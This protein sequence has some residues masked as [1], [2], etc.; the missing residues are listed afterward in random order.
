MIFSNPPVWWT[1]CFPPWTS[2]VEDVGP[3]SGK[4]ASKDEDVGPESE[5]KGKIL[6]PGRNLL[7]SVLMHLG[8]SARK[9]LQLDEK[10]AE[11][12]PRPK[13]VQL[14][15]PGSTSGVMKSTLKPKLRVTK[16]SVKVEENTDLEVRLAEHYSHMMNFI[17]TKAEPILFYLPA[18]HNAE[19]QRC[20]EE[21]QKTIRRKIEMLPTHLGGELEAE[22]W[23]ETPSWWTK[24]L[25]ELLMDE[26][27]VEIWNRTP[28]NSWDNAEPQTNDRKFK[29]VRFFL[30][31]TSS[32]L[33]KQSMKTNQGCCFASPMPEASGEHFHFAVVLEKVVW[34]GATVLV[35]VLVLWIHR[36]FVNE[37]KTQKKRVKVQFVI[38]DRWRMTLHIL[39]KI[40]KLTCC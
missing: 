29:L 36:S 25:E 8:S 15:Q 9:R 12:R 5:K 6:Q 35:L 16:S 2:K 39:N 11:K 38:K 31:I 32:L 22:E 33:F 37:I 30:S 24:R 7:G 17:R 26:K 14:S 34:S 21:T 1:L 10:K 20:L 4:K 27:M 28:R 19:S 23:W 13:I 18:T 40:C 3:E